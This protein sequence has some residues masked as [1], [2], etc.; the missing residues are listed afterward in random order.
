MPSTSTFDAI[1]RTSP[2]YCAGEPRRRSPAKFFCLPHST[3]H[4]DRARLSAW[5]RSTPAVLSS[6]TWWPSRESARSLSPP[7]EFEVRGRGPTDNAGKDASFQ[8]GP[9]CCSSPNQGLRIDISASYRQLCVRYV[10]H[11]RGPLH[12]TGPGGADSAEA[13]LADS[14]SSTVPPHHHMHVRVA[15]LP[16][17]VP[18]LTNRQR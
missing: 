14:I 16:L 9:L 4:G 17:K 11:F 15:S 18:L 6:R 2:V 13:S 10:G 1:R 7:A 8:P 3:G 12:C 5:F